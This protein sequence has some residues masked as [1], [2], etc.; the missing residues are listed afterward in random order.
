MTWRWEGQECVLQ[1][2][3]TDELGQVQ[4]TREQLA[5][6]FNRPA[7]YYHTHGVQGTDNMIQPWKIA[8][9]GSVSNAIA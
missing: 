9:D 1:S 6:F 5:K 8:A 7:D 2:R 3:C 4:P